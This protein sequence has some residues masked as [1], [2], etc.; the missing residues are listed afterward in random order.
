MWFLHR[1]IEALGS[2]GG[3]SGCFQKRMLAGAKPRSGHAARGDGAVGSGSHSCGPQ[4]SP[5]AL[6]GG[7][8]GQHQQPVPPLAHSPSPHGPALDRLWVCPTRPLQATRHTQSAISGPHSAESR[9]HEGTAPGA[10][11]AQ[12]P[13]DSRSQS[14]CQHPFLGP[15]SAWRP[16]VSGRHGAV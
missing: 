3:F 4:L 9:T 16:G 1:A 7:A 14:L 6:A 8:L 5:S 10:G 2:P 11:S 12:R 15:R 13:V